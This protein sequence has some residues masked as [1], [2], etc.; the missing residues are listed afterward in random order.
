MAT[1]S[2][3]DKIM[4]LGLGFWASKTLLSAIELELF[5]LLAK[6][7][8]TQE[9]I[10][11]QLGLHPRSRLDFLDALVALEML[12]RNNGTY[13]NTTETDLYL[14][15]AKS[16]YIGGLLEMANARLYQ[17]WGSLTEG[18]KTGQAQNEA[19][20]SDTF[21]DILYSDPT[22]LKSFLN[23]M[24]GLSMAAAQA[25]AKKFPFKDYQSFLDVG[26]A[27]GGLPVQI[28]QAHPHLKGGGFDIPVTGPIFEEYIASFGLSDRIKFHPGDFFK[29]PLP[30]AEVITMGHIL[31]DWNL[32]EKK[33]LIGK[34]FD[35]L[36]EGGALI[37]FEALID[38]E[39]RANAF[40]LLMS[41]NML[42]ET[43]GGF[44]F[45]G[46]DCCGW[47]KETGFRETRVE[48]LAGPDSM[49]IGIK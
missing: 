37:I 12:E 27:Q 3:P 6:K 36:P 29:D 39:R 14:D 49:V 23:A 41:L 1:L 8:L 31:H 33:F 15:K 26:C 45:T 16:S 47:L 42:I 13:H 9:E 30:P 35:V 11:E 25:I 19:K 38:D 4:K 48:A 7:P 10:G 44:D 24:T 34:A 22:R 18:L 21:F 28:A 32:E 20:G 2:T 43:P 17:H 46:G 5:T 40:G